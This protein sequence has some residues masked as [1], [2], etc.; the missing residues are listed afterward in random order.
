MSAVVDERAGMKYTGK[1][2]TREKRQDTKD[3]YDH[4][5]LQLRTRLTCMRVAKHLESFCSRQ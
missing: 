3:S 1:L 4:W 5:A 2:D